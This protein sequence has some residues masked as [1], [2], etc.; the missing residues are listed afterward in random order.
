MVIEV[1]SFVKVLGNMVIPTKK[2]W[3]YSKRTL[4]LLVSESVRE[5]F[6]FAV[7]F[8]IIDLKNVI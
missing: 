1:K 5:L 2:L 7:K 8:I 3:I 4:I 6:R